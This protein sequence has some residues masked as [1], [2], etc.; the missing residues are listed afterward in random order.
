VTERDRD[1]LFRD[2]V[3][4]YWC[5][6]GAAQELVQFCAADPTKAGATF[7]AEVNGLVSDHIFVRAEQIITLTWPLPQVGSS[8]CSTLMSSLP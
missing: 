7:T 2:R 6:G 1:L 5:E 8:T 3:R 4:F